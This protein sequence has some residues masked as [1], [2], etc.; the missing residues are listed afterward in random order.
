MADLR[1]VLVGAGSRSFGPSTIRDIMLSKPLSGRSVEI[2]LM[3]IIPKHL[4]DILVYGRAVARKLGR[5][6]SFKTT[7]SLAAA[8]RGA[9]YVVSAIEV[10]RY[11]YWAMDFHVPRAFGFA[12]VY[13]EN[14]GPGGMFHAL[15]NMGP[16]LNIARMMQRICPRAVLL[17]F[18]NP[19]TKLCE[20]VSRLTDIQAYGLCH[21]VGMGMA[22]VAQMMERPAESMKMTAC[23]MN[24]FTWFTEI[25]DRKTGEDLYPL[26]R[27]I[28]AE[29]DP[30]AEWHEYALARILFRRFGLFP[31]PAPN[32]YGEYLSWAEEFVAH[33]V[34][35]YF[36]P[37][38]GR[39]WENG[40]IP[41][42]IYSLTY[43]DLKRSLVKKGK[44]K[45]GSWENE[46]AKARSGWIKVDKV[47][48]PSGEVEVS[49]I[50]GMSCGAS[51]RI[52]AVNVRN[53]GAIPNLPADMIVEVPADVDA[54]GVHPVRMEALPEG[55]VGLLRPYASIHKL[56][57]EAYAEHSKNKLV[58]AVLLDPTCRSYRAAVD[59]VDEMIRLQKGILPPL[60]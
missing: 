2:V 27:K 17:N 5:R 49:I 40:K 50:E 23:G 7:T 12:Q 44:V 32:H 35:Y 34:Q 29:G 47:L 14:G 36:D 38:E 22:Y 21:G 11:L 18:T 19:E 30:V 13:G 42:F 8:L 9:D 55:I 52:D 57:V 16:T 48:K 43:S 51:Q 45:A 6:V 24:H 60:R 53:D 58:Q 28:D 4:H 25:R 46:M 1:I 39:P 56:L 15:R 26:L 59:M 33:Q 37:M 20:A 41:E 10:N 3:D 31:S 54:G